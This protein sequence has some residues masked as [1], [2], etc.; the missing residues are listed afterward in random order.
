MARMTTVRTARAWREKTLA[1]QLDGITRDDL[2]QDAASGIA[3]RPKHVG[4]GRAAIEGCKLV[5][6]EGQQRGSG[7]DGFVADGVDH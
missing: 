6:Q 5:T 2:G 1:S 4:R 3:R 7:S